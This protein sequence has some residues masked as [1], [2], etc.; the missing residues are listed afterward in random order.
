MGEAHESRPLAGCR[1]LVT[2]A[3]EQAP[4][5]ARRIET[6]G[7][8]AVIFPLI[9]IRPMGDAGPLDEALDCLDQFD[10][11]IFTSVNTVRL[12]LQRM[13][14]RDI[15]LE[16]LS[17]RVAAVGPKTKAVLEAEGVTVDVLPTEF[18]AEGLLDALLPQMTPGLRVLL[19]RSRI[20]R[21][22][23]PEQL[24]CHGAQVTAVD[25]YDT[26]PVREG[27]AQLASLLENRAV[28]WLTF[29]SSSTVQSFVDLLSGYDVPRLL[30]GVAVAS[31]GP[32]TSATCRKL[33]LP[34]TVEA[35]PSSLDGLI[36]AMV[37]WTMSHKGANADE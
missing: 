33:G 10:W 11:I 13:R 31:I 18:H 2:R 26:E 37:Q 6:L 23:L 27:A 32:L 19:P 1:V 12:F 22:V 5:L 7:G 29:T 4:E 15:P 30:K 36:Q 35:Q 21:E 17:A 3:V 20:A 16:R 34:V 28:H 14:Q 8:E 24:A 25:V 9:R